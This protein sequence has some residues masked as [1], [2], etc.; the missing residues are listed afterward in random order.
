MRKRSTPWLYAILATAAFLGLCGCGSGSSSSE[1][2]KPPNPPTIDIDSTNIL[3]SRLSGVAPLFVYFEANPTQL[4]PGVDPFLGIECRWD[5][6]DPDS[7]NYAS[8]HSRNTHVGPIAAHV[9][10]KPGTYTVAVSVADGGDP[11]TASVTVNVLDPDVVFA[12]STYVFSNT[13]PPNFE[14]APPGATEVAASSLATVASYVAPGRRILLRR[15]ETWVANT[16]FGGTIAGPGIVGAFGPGTRPVIQISGQL[17]APRWTDW[18]IMDLEILG[19]GSSARAFR[20]AGANNQVLVQRVAVR[21]CKTGIAFSTSHSGGTLFDQCAI[22]DCSVNHVVGGLGGYASMFAGSQTALLGNVFDDASGAEHVVRAPWLKGCVIA[23][24]DLGRPAGTK[25]VLKLH[26]PPWEGTG[27]GNHQYSERVHVADN[28]FRGGLAS[29]VVAIVAEDDHT[30][31][32]VRNVLVERNLTLAG[33]SH[34]T[35]YLVS[36]ERFLA[37]NNVSNMTGGNAATMFS[38]TR[39]GIEPIPSDLTILNNTAYTADPDRFTLLSVGSGILVSEFVGN[40]GSAPNTSAANK[41]LLSGV[42]GTNVDNLL[43]DNAQFV[44][45]ANNDFSLQATSPAVDA[46]TLAPAE[47]FDDFDQFIRVPPFDCGAYENGSIVPPP[48]PPPPP[49]ETFELIM[50]NNTKGPDYETRWMGEWYPSAEQSFYGID[51][52]YMKYH[53]GSWYEW[54]GS[55]PPGTYEVFAWWTSRASRSTA[56]KYIVNGVEVIVN[57]RENGGQWNSLGVFSIDSLATIRL[58]HETMNVAVSAD[59]IKLTAKSP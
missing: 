55:V 4:Q 3:V 17:F 7:G 41:S 44:D 22:V 20:S 54:E 27:L 24:N 11:A 59:A 2:A 35:S 37:R 43:L 8:G 56:A 23:Y 40:L 34:Q 51:S 46:M 36:C 18:R 14:G 39:R 47:V 26:G 12:N 31:Q 30:D 9:F 21:D 13:T 52:R 29:W 5:F 58:L 53:P 48:P 32:R 50:D 6:G 49:V 19:T 38:V 25:H 42:V 28:V 33:P 57:Q 45:P 1:K 10:E 16:Q 15:G